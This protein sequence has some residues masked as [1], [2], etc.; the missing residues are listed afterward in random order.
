MNWGNPRTAHQVWDHMTGKAYRAY[1]SSE[2]GSVS[3]QLDR[4][5]SYAGRELGP[6]WLPIALI[7]AAIG[8]VSSWRRQQTLFWYVVLLIAANLAWILFYPVRH[9]QDAY[10]IPSFL[11]LIL[12]FAFGARRI[13]GWKPAVA[14]AILVVPLLAI[15]VAYPLRDRS[16]Y[17]VAHDY[18]QNAL[19][20][21]GPKSLLIAGDWQMY[22]PLR[23][24][25]DVERPRPDVAV[26]E[27]GFLQSDWYHTEVNR[28]YPQL[29]RGCETEQRA[30]LDVLRRLNDD[31]SLWRD[32]SARGELNDRLDDLLIAVI[33]HQLA[34]GP[35]Y[36]TIDT[37]L[38]WDERDKKFLERLKKDH[39]IVPRGVVME[40]VSGH[41]IRDVRRTPI[42]T[43]GLIDGTVRYDD[44]EVVPNE[45]VPTYRAA[46]LSRARYLAVTRHFQDA[47]A[48]YQQALAFD[49]ENRMLEQE[50]LAVQ[51][52]MR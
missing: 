33:A 42:L 31:P 11:A 51:A 35:V 13:A 14:P 48:D 29:T 45:L 4:Y 41:A 22:S 26:L 17:W 30:V 19:S 21:M 50:L 37:A 47:I 15:V 40:L 18:T 34:R 43:R 23:Y 49:P 20:A 1:I 3:A 28:R 25:L 24:V 32:I 7:V 2:A 9:D 8:L 27:T 10:I 46:F 6:P 52:A 39:D 38:A 36:M 44:D 16:R 12:A 5:V